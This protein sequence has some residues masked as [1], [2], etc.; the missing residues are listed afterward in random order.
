MAG[1]TICILGGT[2]FVGGHLANRLVQDQ[3][4]IRILTRR[5]ERHRALLVLPGVDIIEANIHN[6]AD[7][8]KYFTGCDVVINLAG[9]L[10]ESGHAGH[11]FR[12]VHVELARRVVDTCIKTGVKRLLHMSALN[13]DAAKGASVYL[14][15]KG[16]AEMLVHQNAHG[17]LR[18]T[19]FRPSVI[20]GPGDSFFNRFACLLKQIPFAF[21]LA[22]PDA[23]FA[24][25]CVSDVT[26]AFVR[27]IDK[28]QTYGQRYDL[29]GPHAYTLGQL[30]Q[31]TADT[32]GV[33]RRIIRLGD[34]LSRL[35]ARIMQHLPGK[36]FSMDNYNSMKLPSVCNGHF[37]DVFGITLT[38]LEAVVPGYLGKHTYRERCALLRTRAGRN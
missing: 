14:R 1:H 29:C 4:R 16:E 28:P 10:N 23:Q 15:T 35:Q 11:R 36:P 31:Y 24:P 13:A 34:G 20:Y 7:L 12:D 2:G 22:C 30:V 21:P 19:S 26:E 8:R 18:V 25:I 17:R 37:P 5:R 3:H 6:P 33:K 38:P 27:A 32:I 9:I